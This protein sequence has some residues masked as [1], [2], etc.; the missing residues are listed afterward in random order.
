MGDTPPR[1]DAGC[2]EAAMGRHTDRS[3]PGAFSGCEDAE[4]RQAYA[5]CLQRGFGEPHRRVR[6][7]LWEPPLSVGRPPR[8]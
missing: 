4:C 6:G 5:D 2:F 8:G 7:G 1:P 3:H